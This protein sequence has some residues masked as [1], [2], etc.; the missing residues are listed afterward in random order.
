MASCMVRCRGSLPLRIA[1]STPKT[2]VEAMGDFGHA[3]RAGPCRGQFDRQRDSVET[4]TDLDNQRRSDLVQGEG[5]ISGLGSSNEERD[6][7]DLGQ[8]A[9]HHV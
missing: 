5:R 3:D 4:S 2:L 7:G 1:L 6:G 9:E 8:F